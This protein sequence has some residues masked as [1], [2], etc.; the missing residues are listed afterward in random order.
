V[1]VGGQPHALFVEVVCNGATTNASTGG[2]SSSTSVAEVTS[3]YRSAFHLDLDKNE[4]NGAVKKR[5]RA[6][7]AFTEINRAFTEAVGEIGDVIIHMQI[8][9]I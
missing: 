4:L 1:N 3:A 2:G 7:E 9:I 6:M 5:K 8:E